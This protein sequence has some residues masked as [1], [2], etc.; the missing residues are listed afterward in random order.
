MNM[1]VIQPVTSRYMSIK[2]QASKFHAPS[3]NKAQ[4]KLDSDFQQGLNLIVY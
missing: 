1:K 2:Q 4:T 3:T